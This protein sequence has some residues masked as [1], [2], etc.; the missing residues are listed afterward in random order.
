MTTIEDSDV[1]DISPYGSSSVPDTLGPAVARPDPDNEHLDSGQSSS[2]PWEARVRT[3]TGSAVGYQTTVRRIKHIIDVKPGE[4]RFLD[5]DPRGFHGRITYATKLES[6]ISA[7]SDLAAKRDEVLPRYISTNTAYS[8][9][10]EKAEEAAGFS[11]MRILE[12]QASELEEA[13]HDS[14]NALMD[15]DGPAKNFIRSMVQYAEPD[16]DPKVVK[17][18]LLALYLGDYSTHPWYEN[19]NQGW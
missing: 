2:T 5:Y 16:A 15:C 11:E 3:G 6:V 19:F 4:A 13:A 8:D 12:R 10:I 18:E 7:L 1:T 14:W 9:A 17:R